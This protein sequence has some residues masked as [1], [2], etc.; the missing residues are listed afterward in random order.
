MQKSTRLTSL[1]RDRMHLIAELKSDLGRDRNTAA[2]CMLC[3]KV[4][5]IDNDIRDIE[6]AGTEEFTTYRDSH[7]LGVQLS[8]RVLC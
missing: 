7:G 6:L 5:E 4:V 8:S 3:R 2:I 1:K